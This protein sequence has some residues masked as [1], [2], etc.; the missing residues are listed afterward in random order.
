[1]L[2]LRY[3]LGATDDLLEYYDCFSGMNLNPTDKGISVS[4][5]G[6]FNNQYIEYRYKLHKFNPIWLSLV[7]RSINIIDLLDHHDWL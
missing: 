4:D 6:W 7:S 3:L 2:T 1:M 5:N